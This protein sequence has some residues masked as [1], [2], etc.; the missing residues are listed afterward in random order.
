MYFEIRPES[1]EPNIV[2][3]FRL[4]IPVNSNRVQ[5]FWEGHKNLCLVNVKTIRRMAQIFVAF[6]EKL[7]FKIG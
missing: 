6:S 5:L 2:S 3:E 1:D 4:L 7:N